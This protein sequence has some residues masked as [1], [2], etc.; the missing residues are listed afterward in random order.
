MNV[1]ETVAALNKW[2]HTVGV[3]FK[4]HHSF[5]EAYARELQDLGVPV[6]RVWFS[7][8]VLHPLVAAA[9]MKWE[10]SGNFTEQSWSRKEYREFRENLGSSRDSL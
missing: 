10:S 3:N 6:D 8:L 4:E 7:A 9:A 5:A 1:S 2:L